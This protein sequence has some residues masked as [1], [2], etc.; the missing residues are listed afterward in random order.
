M[1][2]LVSQNF[3]VEGG[4]VNG[5]RGTVKAIRYILDSRGRRTLTSV[6]VDIPNSTC[7][8]LP[9]LENK[10][11]PI[12][13]D[14][15]R[16]V[17]QNPHTRAS[18]TIIRHQ[19]PVVPAFA[20]TTHRAQGQTYD[21]VI[22]DLQSCRGTESPYVMVSRATSLDGLFILRSFDGRKIRCGLSEEN[23]ME[24]R[25]VERLQL[26]TVVQYGNQL[27]VDNA[28]RNLAEYGSGDVHTNVD[29]VSSN[30]ACSLLD[31]LQTNTAA[32]HLKTTSAPPRI[33]KYFS[34]ELTDA[35][36]RHRSVSDLDARS[37]KRRHELS[38]SS[39][40]TPNKRKR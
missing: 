23:R 26:E 39:N 5:S 6:I 38:S 15:S 4:V 9:T 24:K 18:R 12:L 11:I 36:T 17:F 32:L 16:L 7:E 27:E 8:A 20:M 1:P 28:K 22:V 2:V 3:D 14:T 35:L 37:T 25:R 13:S 31:I 29:T 21:K 10:S 40:F 33:Q 19:V 34:T 30:D